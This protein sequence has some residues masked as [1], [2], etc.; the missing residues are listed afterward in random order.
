MIISAGRPDTIGFELDVIPVNDFNFYQGPFFP[1]ANPWDGS[2][3]ILKTKEDQVGLG[4]LRS[5]K[6]TAEMTRKTFEYMRANIQMGLTEME[7][8]GMF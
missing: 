6:N 5:W 2:P 1:T 3:L 4:K 7:F 8:A